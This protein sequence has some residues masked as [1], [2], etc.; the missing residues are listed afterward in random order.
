MF[1]SLKLNAWFYKWNT[2][3]SSHWPPK[4]PFLLLTPKLSLLSLLPSLPLSCCSSP[5]N[6]NGRVE[7]HSV[8][9][10]C[11]SPSLSIHQQD[12]SPR[13]WGDWL[14]H[15]EPRAPSSIHLSY[16]FILLEKAQENPV[17]QWGKGKTILLCQHNHGRIIRGFPKQDR[18]FIGMVSRANKF[19]L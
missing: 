7:N 13:G 17:F 9:P 14:K 3:A 12:Q 1:I 18:I 16:R 6:T 19:Q 11:L 15:K 4:Y 2:E 10:S 5:R 8:S